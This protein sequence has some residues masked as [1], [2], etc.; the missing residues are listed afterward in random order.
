[1]VWAGLQ[2]VGTLGSQTRAH[3]VVDLIIRLHGSEP[4]FDY[5]QLLAITERGGTLVLHRVADTET[6]AAAVWQIASRLSE[7]ARACP[8][9]SGA[10]WAYDHNWMTSE[11]HAEAVR[12]SKVVL[13]LQEEQLSRIA[14]LR[15][16]LAS[17]R[18]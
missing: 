11:E 18:R 6:I 8:D 4:S 17:I 15:T 5:A 14:S 9:L 12:K 7:L 2:G 1:L 13:D 10:D 3:A 16:A